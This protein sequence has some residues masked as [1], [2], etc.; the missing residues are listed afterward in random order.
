MTQDANEEL[1]V[2]TNMLWNSFG[3]LSYL[4]CQWLMTVLVVR[5][6]SGFDAAGSL[7]LAMSVYNMFSS[8]ALYRMY[9]YQVS[10][11]RHENT[12]G[13]YFGLRIITCLMALVMIAV[14]SFMTCPLNSI[15]A[16]LS[17]SLYKIASLL[18]DVLHGLDQQ[19]RRMDYIGKSLAIQGAISL[20]AFC[21]FLPL[22]NDLTSTFLCM[23][24]GIVVIGLLYDRPRAAQFEALKVG[25]SRKK[26]AYLLTS[27]LPIVVAGIACGAAPSLPRQILASIDGTAAL[28][29]Y[30]SVAAPAAIVQMG[31]SYIYNPLL[32]YFSEAYASKDIRQL[33]V[34]LLKASAAIALIGILSAIALLIMGEPLLTLMYGTQIAPYMYLMTPIIIC[35]AVTA[36]VWFLNDLLVALRHF[37]GSFIGNTC[38]FALTIP[39]AFWF[40]PL[41]GMNGVSFAIILAYGASATIMLVC[42]IWILHKDTK[43][44]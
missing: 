39:A 36:Y 17:F 6:S 24:A 27:C 33:T 23:T 1:S 19:H 12:V 8:V 16:I 43:T 15:G 44:N 26:T 14:Y 11:V 10:D 34:L 3:S 9:T 35:T 37:R 28:G 41:F 18:I 30:A 2:K 4:G 31:A 25:I 32:G 20:I 29:I 7:S 5:L 21:S 42:L 13:E 22:T 38:A 40:I